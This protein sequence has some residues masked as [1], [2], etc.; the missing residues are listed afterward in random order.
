MKTSKQFYKELGADGL[1]KRKGSAMNKREFISLKKIINKNQ[2]IL[3]LGCGYGR[4]TIPLS[5]QGYD[6]EGIDISPNLLNEAK[7]MAKKERLKIKF[8][9]G[10]MRYLPYKKESF[11]AIICM[12]SVFQ[13]IINIKDQLKAI[14]EMLRV[15]KEGGFA[16]IDIPIS[17]KSG[18]E[19][20][21]IID[22]VKTMP[23]YKQNKESLKK[24][25]KKSKIEKYKITI[26]N[27]GGRDRQLLQFWK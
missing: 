8:K 10:D 1:A 23:Y 7:K 22:G 25:M 19:E 21:L 24:L 26:S 27:F 17:E 16:F 12:W 5:K 9:L 13:E 20:T 6:I 2:K 3:D 15:L 11:N 14:K 18:F 4:F